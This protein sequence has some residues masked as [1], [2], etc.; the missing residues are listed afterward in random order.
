MHVDL[1]GMRALVTGSTAGIGYA[2]AKALALNGA[3][4]AINGRTHGRVTEAIERLRD[5]GVGTELIP[6]P[7][8]ISTA[9]GAEKVIAASGELDIL[10]NN[11][12]IFEPKDA[13]EIP[14]EDW[15]RLFETN[16]L[17]PI[18]LTR[19]YGPHMRAKG[20][21]RIVFI[22]SES[23]IQIPTEMI[24]YGLTKTAMLSLTRGF[25]QALAQTGVTVNAVL[26]GPTRSEGVEGFVKALAEQ[27]GVTEA[28]IED[29]FFKS[30]RPSSLLKRFIT[31][32]EVADVVLFVCSREAAAI[33]GAPVRA[34][35]GVLQSIA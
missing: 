11:A 27:G 31:P 35:G 19:H 25:A 34:E 24:H 26:P 7:G 6:A 22:S 29:E 14:D 10:V 21:G 8:D 5:E 15:T 4:V 17:G 2:I 18:R 13:F 3:A 23:A 33:T 12:G 20:W 9:E 1:K 16:V 30:A 32:E 28:Q